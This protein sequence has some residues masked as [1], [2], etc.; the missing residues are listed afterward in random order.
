MSHRKA[1]AI[2]AAALVLAAGTASAQ[3][4]VGRDYTLLASPQPTEAGDKVEVLE[5]FSYGCGHCYRLETHIEKWSAT[6]PKDIV[7]KRVPAVS[8]ESWA[9]LGLIYYTLESMGLLEKY[10]RRVFDAI[11]QDNINLGNRKVRD[12]WLAKQGIDVAKFTE[13]EKSFS[14]VTKMNRAKQMSVAYKIDGVPTMIVQ[15]KY[16]TNNGLAGGYDRVMPLVEKIAAMA[17]GGKSTPVA[18]K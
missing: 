7:F 5:F 13:V 3:L 10:H 18:A 12:D 4:Q 11:H 14:V 8:S 17:R 16:V 6:A 2:A 1:L 15:G 9:Q